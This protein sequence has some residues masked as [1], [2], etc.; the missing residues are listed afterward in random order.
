MTYLLLKQIHVTCVVLTLMG[1]MLRLLFM[2]RQSPWLRTRFARTLPH[3]VDTLLLGSA[4]GL[5]LQIHQYPLVNGWLT[6]KVAGLIAYIVL[7]ATS[8]RW[9]RTK[10]QRLVAGIAALAAFS[11]IVAVAT[12]KDGLVGV[13]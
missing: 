2:L 6:A 1:F 3:V 8:L 5:T 4:I 7:G 9:G 13:A 11:Y 12:T 10:T